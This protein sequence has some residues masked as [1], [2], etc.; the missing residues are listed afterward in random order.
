MSSSQAFS[1]CY[2]P[3]ISDCAGMESIVCQLN[4]IPI[5]W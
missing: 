3:L 4:H 5:V 1:A 2:I